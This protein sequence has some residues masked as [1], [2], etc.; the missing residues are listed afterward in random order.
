MIKYFII[1][2][3]FISWNAEGVRD[4]RKVLPDLMKLGTPDLVKWH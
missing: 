3:L 4:Q 2:S 1:R